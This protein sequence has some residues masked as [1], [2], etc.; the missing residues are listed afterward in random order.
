[1]K[2]ILN[3][4]VYSISDDI[5][6]DKVEKIIPYL[7]Q[8]Y[9]DIFKIYE[10]F[11]LNRNPI[12]DRSGVLPHYLNISPIHKMPTDKLFNS[13]FYDICKER[14]LELAS[15]GKEIKICWS[16]GIDSTFV[17]FFLSQYIPDDQITVYGTYSSI[18][19]SGNIFD[20]Y[21]KHKFKSEIHIHPTNDIKNNL[22]N[23]IWVT[24]FQGNQLFGPTDDFF[25][26][27]KSIA[28][29]HHTLGTKETIYE[30]YKK[31]IDPDILEFLQPC[32]D[33]SPRKIETVADLRWYCIFNLD[34]YNGLY[35]TT[36]EMNPKKINTFHHFF[37]T[38]NFQ[39]WAINTKE[40][41]TKIK[42]QPNTHRWQM[43]DFLADC[44]LK[45]YAKNKQKS[46]S[47]LS[48]LKPN[49]YFML[50]DFT[51]VYKST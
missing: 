23:C 12:Y 4:N 1:L 49:W 22:Q 26:K 41:F 47:C 42:G 11:G 9:K 18:I 21:I 27:N 44:G 39:K 43:R 6:K 7:T 29:F 32:I 24:G 20:L 28:F 25:S 50:E 34:W 13:S 8:N 33:A 15:Y 3:Y 51:N 37:N 30:N 46:I 45:N 10:K 31:N 35:E 48:T 5:K 40:P 17:L 38:E 14:A 16:G 36:S 19:E 2:K